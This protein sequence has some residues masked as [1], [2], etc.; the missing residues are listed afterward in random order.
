MQLIEPLVQ[1]FDGL[2]IKYAIGSNE[3]AIVIARGLGVPTEEEDERWIQI[4][5]MLD[6]T[7]VL[8]HFGGT[9]KSRCGERKF[10]SASESTLSVVED[11]SDVINALVNGKLK[12]PPYKKVAVIGSSF[13]AP[14]ALMAG[15]RSDYVE[16]ILSVS[17]GICFPAKRYKDRA[18]NM[19]RL[20]AEHRKDPSK[21][22]GVLSEDG[23]HNY[24]GFDLEFALG[25][26][27]GKP[28]S[29][30]DYLSE[31]A[32]KDLLL[33]H[34]KGDHHLSS[35]RS[36]DF[37]KKIGEYCR[38]EGLDPRVRLEVTDRINNHKTGKV[39]TPN[40]GS[41]EATPGFYR[42]VFQFLDPDID[43][44]LVAQVVSYVNS[45]YHKLPEPVRECCGL[46]E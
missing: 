7:V 5:N 43:M 22:W 3:E 1:R 21:P 28:I 44:G 12:V 25:V 36:I 31:L 38:R 13:G 8:P 29:P 27:R 33:V 45:R 30:Y 35:Q 26:L 20:L 15:A 4:L 39:T 23:K 42:K 41:L 17:G 10:L 32:R 11:I 16:K 9:Y 34:V 19:F 6:Y 18:E 2:S 37:F 40:H 46:L 24:I 14:V